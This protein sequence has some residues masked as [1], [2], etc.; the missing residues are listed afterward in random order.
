[1]KKTV[2][3]FG[4]ISGAVSSLLMAATVPFMDQLGHGSMGYVVGYTGIV[5][6][7]MLVYFGVRSYRDN[8]GGGKISFGKA[9]QV[10]ILI[11]LISCA[12]Y[13]VTWEIIYFNFVP[14]FMDKYGAS[15]IE[16]L[17][18]SG[19]SEAELQKKIAELNK[20]K[21]MYKNPLINA[22][23]TFLEPFPV[24]LL[25]TLITAGIVR[26]NDDAAIPKAATV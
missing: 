26:K 7:F 1:M 17:R 16:K 4:L 22:A 25:M 6:S 23:M 15:V 5:L 11:T 20:F 24:G 2:I 19:A 12:F 13:V 21:E 18:S 14:D 8:V 3:T 9:F 10:G